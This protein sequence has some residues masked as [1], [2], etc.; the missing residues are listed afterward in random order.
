MSRLSQTLPSAPQSEPFLGVKGLLRNTAFMIDAML[1]PGRIIAEVS[2]M[3]ALML[4]ANRLEATD[5][6][7]AA[8]LRQR[9]VRIG[10]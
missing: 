5:P 10:L 9:A 4:Q 2:E 3:R 8:K 1:F 7:R 6:A